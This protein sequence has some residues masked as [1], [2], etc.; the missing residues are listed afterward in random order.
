MSYECQSRW[1]LTIHAT[2]RDNTD[3]K[4]TRT[5]SLRCA[6]YDA[7]WKDSMLMHADVS[8]APHESEEESSAPHTDEEESSYKKRRLSNGGPLCNP[9]L[10]GWYT[11]SELKNRLGEDTA[12]RV[13]RT[14]PRR[15]A[16][17]GCDKLCIEQFLV[18]DGVHSLGRLYVPPPL[19]Y[20]G[21]R[22]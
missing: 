1:L 3:K 5:E 2:I 16:G 15:F 18:T 4:S 14:A 9:M 21:H 8:M 11:M 10:N 6:D 19:G 22:R 12:T 7:S 17:Q 13:T 20:P